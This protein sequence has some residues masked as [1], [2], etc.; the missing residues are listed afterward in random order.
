MKAAFEKR[1]RVMEIHLDKKA[2]RIP[3]REDVGPTKNPLKK[4]QR[5]VQQDTKTQWSLLEYFAFLSKRAIV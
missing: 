1:I 2:G 3:I 4:R 5:D